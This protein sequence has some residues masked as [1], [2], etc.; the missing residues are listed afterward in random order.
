[1]PLFPVYLILIFSLTYRNLGFA[2]RL[3]AWI[4]DRDHTYY[5]AGHIK[6][7][8]N[9]HSTILFGYGFEFLDKSGRARVHTDYRFQVYSKL[10]A[11]SL[12]DSDGKF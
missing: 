8:F 3:P 7:V 6:K 5:N 9:M 4:S 2:D 12:R 10:F 11:A 1:M